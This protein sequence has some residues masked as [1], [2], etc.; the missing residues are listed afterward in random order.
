[1]AWKPGSGISETYAKMKSEVSEADG[2]KRR[3]A[4]QSK[5]LAEESSAAASSEISGGGFSRNRR[6]RQ[7][8]SEAAAAKAA[9]W[10]E[11]RP[12]GSEKR[13]SGRS[14]MKTG[15]GK[16]AIGGND[17]K[18]HRLKTRRWSRKLAASE[19]SA[20][21]KQHQ[22]EIRK[23]GE[24]SGFAGKPRPMAASAEWQRMAN[25]GERISVW[26][27]WPKN[28]IEQWKRKPG[29]EAKSA[30]IWRKEKPKKWKRRRLEAKRQ[31]PAEN[32]NGDN[33]EKRKCNEEKSKI[34][35]LKAGERK[36]VAGQKASKKEGRK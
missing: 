13:S 30:K 19:I 23:T 11:K 5:I 8:R 33:I 25:N 35:R 9:Y 24:R 28:K 14:E 34:R 3:K 15:G 7:Y 16:L 12:A 36:S 21:A 22:P 10:R 31:Y 1:M 26:Q 6:R 29:E 4:R 27:N 18:R 2:E 17:W 32:E 20:K